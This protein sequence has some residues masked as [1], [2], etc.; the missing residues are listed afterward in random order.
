[1]SFLHLFF[2][3]KQSNKQSKWLLNWHHVTSISVVFMLVKVDTGF[4]HWQKFKILCKLF[5][6]PGFEPH[7]PWCLHLCY[8]EFV[9]QNMTRD[10]IN[11]NNK[12][13]NMLSKSLKTCILNSYIKNS[14]NYISS[15]INAYTNFAKKLCNIKFM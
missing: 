8:P 13:L 9:Y 2:N 3:V 14:A 15:I 4:S 5:K 11:Y 12:D 10:I 1:M 7:K 6:C